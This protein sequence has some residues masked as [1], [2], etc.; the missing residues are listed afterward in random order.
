M[1]SVAAAVVVFGA[2]ALAVAHRHKSLVALALAFSPAVIMPVA[3]AVEAASSYR[4][5]TA[6]LWASGIPGRTSYGLID[7]TTRIPL[8]RTGCFGPPPQAPIHNGIVRALAWL[9]PAP[10]TFQ[11]SLPSEAEV[12]NALEYFGTDLRSLCVGDPPLA[13]TEQHLTGVE[14]HVCVW[15]RV[16]D[17]GDAFSQRVVELEDGLIAVETVPSRLEPSEHPNGCRSEDAP[18]DPLVYHVPT[19]T[20]LGSPVPR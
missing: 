12:R 4:S 7:Q 15:Y 10:G 2:G 9:S 3:W 8:Q 16:S 17:W 6:R 1:V 13:E 5:G 19:E 14:Q 18:C 20:L 11:G